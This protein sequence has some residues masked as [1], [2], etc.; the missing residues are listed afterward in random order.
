MFFC[1]A[2]CYALGA[3]ILLVIPWRTV[4]WIILFTISELRKAAR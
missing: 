2:V 3:C 1:Q 4:Q